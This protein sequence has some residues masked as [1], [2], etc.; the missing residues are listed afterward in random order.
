MQIGLNFTLGSTLELVQ[1][2]VREGEIDY[3]ELLIDNFLQ[4]PPEE[5]AAAFDCPV[6]FHI[7]F[8]K[9]LESD[10]EYLDSMAERLHTYIDV[11]KPMY[12]S[13]HV[14]RFNHNGRQ[15]Y[16]LAELDYRS[17]YDVLRPKVESWQEKLGQRLYL[18]NYPSIMDS[19]L[20][21]PAFF[22]RIT[23]ETGAGMFFDASN[24]VC[25][26]HNCG[27]PLE[28]WENLISSTPHFHVASYNYSILDPKI[29]LDTHDG[30]LA[31]D[32]LAFLERYKD[33]F[34]KPGATMTYERDVNIEY[35]AI[36][37]DLRKLRALFGNSTEVKHVQ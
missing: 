34:D 7:M 15:L 36:V 4:V 3:C 23:C 10:P 27:L 32:T 5:L 20:D 1:R 29:V 26:H 8:S 19:G 12:V 9:F 31:D 18:E 37:A 17:E 2:L 24:A 22:E 16:H 33:R 21:A 13:D 25:A 11:M 6:G 30:P 14:A 28:A 35:D